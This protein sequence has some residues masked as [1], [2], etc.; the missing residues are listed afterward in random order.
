MAILNHFIKE[1]G[2]P[3]HE[4]VPQPDN[5][6]DPEFIEDEAMEENIDVSDQLNIE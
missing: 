2:H 6:H 4:N 3:S 5:I 1:S